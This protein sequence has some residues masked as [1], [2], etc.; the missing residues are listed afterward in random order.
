MR[1]EAVCV[2]LQTLA[3][4]NVNASHARKRR[5]GLLL[6]DVAEAVVVGHAR[7]GELCSATSG[8]GGGGIKGRA[9][10]PQALWK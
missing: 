9:E 3:L 1:G 2:G 4:L 5:G 8:G 7:L 10:R 6:V